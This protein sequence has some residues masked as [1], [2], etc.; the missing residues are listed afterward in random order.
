MTKYPEHCEG[1]SSDIT[2]LKY[3]WIIQAARKTRICHYSSYDFAEAGVLWKW[4]IPWFVAPWGRTD[5]NDDEPR[6][7]QDHIKSQQAG[8][9]NVSED[10]QSFARGKLK[11]HVK[12]TYAYT[13]T[14][15]QTGTVFCII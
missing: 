11:Y 15:A 3:S 1:K 6:T 7:I 14:C 8:R 9:V 4:P 2:Q 13:R 5:N 10:R 12:R